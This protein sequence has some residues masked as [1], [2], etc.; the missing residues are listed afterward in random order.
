MFTLFKNHKLRFYLLGG[1]VSRLG[2]VLT[3]I[4]FLFLAHGMTHTTCMEIVRIMMKY[5]CPTP[6]LL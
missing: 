2:D 5:G 3:W 6:I 1:R 4:A